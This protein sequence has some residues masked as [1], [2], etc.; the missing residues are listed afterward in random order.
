MGNQLTDNHADAIFSKLSKEPTPMEQRSVHT[1]DFKKALRFSQDQIR[2]LTRIHDNCARLLTSYLS[3]QLRTHVQISVA[4]VEQFTYEDFVRNVQK[5]SILGVFNAP[6]LQGSMLME[7]SPDL[8]YIMLDRMLGGQGMVSTVQ[9]EL[10]EIEMSVIER[11]FV[12]AL[13][14]FGEAWESVVRISPELKE[15]EVNPQFLTTSV[16]NETVI[17]V[18]LQTIIG[19]SQGMINICLPHVV[20]EQVLPKLSARHWLANQKKA[21]QS[22][23]ALAL[24]QKVQSTRLDVKAVLGRSSITIGDFL[25][26]KIGDVIRLNESITDPVTILVDE[27]QK[28]LA[29]PG[30]SKGRVAVQITGVQEEGEE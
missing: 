1:Y 20:L 29:Q 15:I 24:E 5:K 16:P 25:D 4:S 9:N 30:I 8:T 6:P 13:E 2:T 22:H 12:N 27:K 11:V 17:L 3:A 28:F 7:F 18:T 14:T 26:L 21:I 23:E 19:D 10:T